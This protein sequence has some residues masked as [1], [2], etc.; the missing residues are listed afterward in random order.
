[1]EEVFGELLAENVTFID[2]ASVLFGGDGMTINFLDGRS[3]YKDASHLTQSGVEL[4]R[5]VLEEALAVVKQRK[6]TDVLDEAR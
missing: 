4:C 1:M 2:A 5:P 3:L 6:V